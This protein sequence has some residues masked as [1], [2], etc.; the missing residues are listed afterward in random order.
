M[1]LEAGSAEDTDDLALMY[2]T[3][4]GIAKRHFWMRMKGM[5]LLFVV[6]TISMVNV[7]PLN[8]NPRHP[9]YTCSAHTRAISA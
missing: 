3:P 4:L 7:S 8:H 1:M 5:T 6:T 2:N 9:A